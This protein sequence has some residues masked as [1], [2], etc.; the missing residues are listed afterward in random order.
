[1]NDKRLARMRFNGFKIAAALVIC[2]AIGFLINHSIS[3]EQNELTEVN[4]A[5][6]S[7]ELANM[8]DSYSPVNSATISCACS[9]PPQ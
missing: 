9:P 7:I 4:L 6:Y 2:L 1:M 8:D 5:D 3:P